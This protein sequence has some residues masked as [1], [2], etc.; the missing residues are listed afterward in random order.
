MGFLQQI[1][2]IFIN[3]T[4]D[5]ANIILLSSS[6]DVYGYG[7]NSCGELGLGTCK[8]ISNPTKIPELCGKSI[9]NVVFG[10]QWTACLTET[11]EVYTWGLESSG[12]LGR[13]QIP[14]GVYKPQKIEL[15]GKL[16]IDIKLGFQTGTLLTN[17]NELY[18]FGRREVLL[19]TVLNF[20][21]AKIVDFCCCCYGIFALTDAG[22]VYLL[23][24]SSDIPEIL[25]LA[26][27]IVVKSISCRYYC[28][29][30][31]LTTEGKIFQ[32][33]FSI[34][35]SDFESN[36]IEIEVNIKFTAILAFHNISM[37]LTAK[38][39]IMVWGELKNGWVNK[40]LQTDFSSFQDA[41]NAHSQYTF[42]YKPLTPQ[43]IF[44]QNG[45]N[46]VNP[47][48]DTMTRAFNDKTYSDLKFKVKRKNSEQFEY[49]Y[50]HKWYITKTCDYFET[51]FCREWAESKCNEIVVSDHSY[52]AFYNFV[53]C[54]YTDSVDVE[55]IELL[56]EILA[57]C[58]QYLIDKI[59][60]KL[61]ASLKSLVKIENVA[62]VY[63]AA[64]K[65][66]CLD[67]EQNCFKF[68]SKNIKFVTKTE[69]FE[70]MDGQY[71]KT[72]LIEFSKNH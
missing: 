38:N 24:H 61:A 62:S 42:L 7:R 5:D 30:L 67:L 21:D 69:N 31:L 51:M 54:L 8:R 27:D 40:P 37:A 53:R 59:K 71:V 26:D 57:I 43:S 56:I 33:D 35:L 65:Y 18:H 17:S 64:L 34:P 2:L 12:S 32:F 48:I 47:V 25:P 10:H 36:N 14:V 22:K 63:S 45:Q 28:K 29:L 55:D 60:S 6:D 66:R 50:T 20:N 23:R 16:V 1:K 13:G 58:D 19:P 39:R 41:I 4:G 9:K 52:E 70:Q 46:D 3:G 49:I 72:F 15:D 44:S 68:M 11:M